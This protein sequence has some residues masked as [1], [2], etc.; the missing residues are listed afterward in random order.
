M[1]RNKCATKKKYMVCTSI[2]T[3]AK[4]TSQFY[5]CLIALILPPHLA[6]FTILLRKTL[7]NHGLIYY[8]CLYF[9]CR[10]YLIY[11]SIYFTILHRNLLC[12]FCISCFLMFCFNASVFSFIKPYTHKFISVS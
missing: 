11:P 10:P 7:K 8:L 4:F 9:F 2:S 12:V 3:I 5:F 1:D 6:G